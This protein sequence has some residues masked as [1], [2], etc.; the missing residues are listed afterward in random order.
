MSRQ[1][2]NDRV[3]RYF[4]EHSGSTTLE[5]IQDLGIRNITARMSDLRA[6][7]VEFAKW[8]DDRGHWRFR[9]REPGQRT[10]FDEIAS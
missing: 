7:G 5:A 9:V 2:Q 8:V 1:T 3:L 4:R 10:L 6:Q